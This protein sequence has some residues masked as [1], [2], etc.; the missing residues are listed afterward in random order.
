[1]LVL[2]VNCGSSSIKYQVREVAPAGEE[3]EAYTSSMPAINEN[4]NL[5]RA[6]AGVESG[7]VITQGLIENIGTSE[8]QNHTQALEILARRL[9]EELGGRTIDAAGHR[10][11]HGGER[12]SAP[13]LVNNEIIRAIERLAPLAPLHNP[14]HALGLRAIQ[15][16][17]PGMPQVCV[18]DT[19]FHRTMPEKAWRYAI[20]DDWYEM[21]GMRRYGFHGTSHD[22][23]TGKACEFLGIPREQFNAVV[24]HLGNGA[25]ATAIRQGRSYD[26]SMGYTPLAGLVMGTRSGDLDPSVVTAM[27][28]R[29]PGMSANDL[30]RVLNNESGLRGICGDS[31]MRAVEQRAENGHERAQRALEMAAYRLAKYIGGYHVAVGG[32]QAL[33]FTAGIGEHSPMFRAMVCDQLGA[34]GIDLDPALNEHPQGDVARISSENSAIEVLVVSTDEERAIAEA[35][36]ALVWERVKN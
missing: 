25:S 10:V 29:N 15:K 23:V 4:V 6:T 21:H 12:F 34:L 13:V 31:D 11:V 8:V 32:A 24:A 16:T 35:T 3:P 33:I 14:A 18:F 1:M 36:A 28:E 26:T 9:E 7:E 30:N 19:A 20:P 5:A 22:Y 17:W 27:L 2:V